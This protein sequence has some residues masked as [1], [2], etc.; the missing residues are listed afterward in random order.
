MRGSGPIG[1]GR[2]EINW[3]GGG[4]NDMT[5]DPPVTPF[6]VFLNTRGAQFITRGERL[7]ARRLLKADPRAA[8][9]DLFNNGT[10]DDI[11]AAF[12]PLR[13]FTPVG[14]NVT[15]ALFLIPGMNP[16]PVGINPLPREGEGV[17]RGFHR[18]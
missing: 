18:C 9:E 10:Y 7:D 1:V 17:W 8:L 14:S 6:N 11:F 15:H 5:D 13:L 12:S 2:R 4:N 16:D 3:D